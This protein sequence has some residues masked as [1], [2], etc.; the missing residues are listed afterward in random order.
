MIR[1]D[2]VLVWF[3]RDLRV[4]DHAA[5]YHALRNGRRVHCAFVFDTEILDA[6]VERA[7]RRVEFI[8]ASVKELQQALAGLRGGLYVLRGRARDEIPSLAARLAVGAVFANRDYEPQAVERDREVA[9]R[10]QAAGRDLHLFKDQTVF[11][12]DELLTARGEPFTV[13]TPYKR[14]W[15]AKLAPFH[16]KAYPV[17]RYRGALAPAPN[18]PHPSLADLGFL[19]T[20]LKDI[21]LPTGMSGARALFEDFL[22]RID[23]YHERRNHPALRG[24]SYLSVHLR[25][26][27]VSIRELAAAAS[28]RPSE[29][30]GTWL[31][32][33]IWRDFYFAILHHFPHV[34]R[35]AFRHEHDDLQ[36]PDP[37]GHFEA[38]CE[39]RTGY[40]LVDAAM[41]QINQSGYMHNRLRMVT[42]SFLSKDLHV[43]WRRG[44]AFFAQRLND[45]DL[46][47][48]NGGW[49]WA[50]STGCDPQPYFR[51]FNPVLQSE[52][53]DPEGRFIRLYLPEL[54]NVPLS[55][56]HTPWLMPGEV[57]RAARCIVG[58]DYPAPL[59]DHGQARR[60]TLEI[61][62]RVKS[63]RKTPRN[64][65]P[66]P[67]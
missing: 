21:A 22:G 10:L 54:A 36:F 61:Y 55:Y 25:F 6:L 33:L 41:R 2:D 17:E 39:A 35:G 43:D 8:L 13:F 32:E 29:G 3:R 26:G 34:T 42:A 59:V 1:Y 49:Q 46:A 9:T 51:I 56:L 20:N 65:L 57:Q 66:A 31:S 37:P 4:D 24:P 63:E 50:A 44:E 30:A 38:W 18:A 19:P 15:L 5:L 48:N 67:D 58:K 23:A 60:K 64:N 7:D 40:P 14:A 27:T 11:D 28:S 12:T 53:F 52:R 16:V 45:F 62:G 47:A